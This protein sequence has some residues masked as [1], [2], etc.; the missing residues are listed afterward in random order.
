MVHKR[1]RETFCQNK[2]STEK[3]AR[4]NKNTRNVQ[5]FMQ[6]QWWNK[7]NL[8]STDTAWPASSIDS[9]FFLHLN[10]VA[11]FTHCL[12]W[13]QIS[14]SPKYNI[15][16]NCMKKCCWLEF[17]YWCGFTIYCTTV[18]FNGSV[19]QYPMRQEAGILVTIPCLY[20]F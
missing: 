18:S 14:P 8:C 1:K 4:R 7:Q 15:K 16:S 13:A 6:H 12:F 2:N 17:K 19:P 20:S 10:I 11:D 3:C 9:I 5:Q